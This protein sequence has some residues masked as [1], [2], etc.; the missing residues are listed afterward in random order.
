MNKPLSSAVTAIVFGLTW[1]CM[2]S[3]AA[4]GQVNRTSGAAGNPFIKE[5]VDA[6]SRDSL[7]SC[8][9]A[10]QAFGTRYEYTPQRDSAGA[11]LLRKFEERG[12]AAQS[13]W[14]GFGTTILMD[15]EIV[16]HDSIWV[17]GLNGTLVSSTDAGS[18][19]GAPSI[20]VRPAFYG[21]DF[22]GRFDGWVVGSAGTI[23]RTT[24]G[25]VNWT[26][27]TS[28]VTSVL[29]DVGF[30]DNH[31]GIA[32][33]AGGTIIRSSDGGV[34]WAKVISGTGAPLRSVAVIDSAHAWAVGDSGRIC[35]SNDGGKSWLLQV[36]GTTS[37]LNNLDFASAATGWAVGA[38]PTLLKTTNGGVSWVSISTPL[39]S[40][41]TLRSIS[42]RDS[43]IGWVA[44][45]AGDILSTADGGQTWSPRYNHLNLGWGPAIYAVQADPSGDVFCCGSQ[46]TLT[47]SQNGGG[48]WTNLTGNLPAEYLRTSRNIVATILGTKCPERECIIV[49][50]YDSFSDNPTVSAPGANDNAT[51]TSAVMEAARAC[52]L[53]A[54]ES[55]V[56]FLLVSAEEFGMYGSG[57]YARRARDGGREIAGVVNGDMIGYPTTGDTAR[58]VIGSFITR[59]R[60]IDSA[61]TYNSRY[62]IGLRLVP[63]IDQ[64]GASDY[65][66]FAKAGYDALEVAE[67]TANEIWGG[68]DPYY[69]KTSD[70]FDKLNLGMIR[71]AA[72]L[73]LATVAELAV[74]TG[75]VTS[76]P[77]AVTR[78]ELHVL[79]QNY[80]NPFNPS[81]T[82]RYGLPSRSQ[83]IVTVFNT[84]GQSVSI[85]MDGE[86]EAGYHEVR[87]DGSNLPSGVYF[88]RMQ[89]GSHTETKKLLLVR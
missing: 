78:P 53:Y 47:R 44:S 16:S 1:L 3:P 46:G 31:L 12:L 63:V 26:L 42:F 61:L 66:P 18:T 86:Q 21:M 35:F 28:P 73:M 49:A 45:L 39:Q 62:G 75:R 65:G 51:G 88:Y 15:L 82:I 41:S 9:R 2:S 64:T 24:D 83:V 87:F 69:H 17:I 48:L 58:I 33:G 50:H 29:Y 40:G 77:P 74:P 6:V 36:S 57:N 14:Y 71:R 37:Q 81:T 55:T 32:V 7:A 25:G 85:L 22:S 43:L 20:P 54:F 79:C 52:R 60:H 68:A 80:P 13:D 19:W 59:N 76:V 4:L 10:L 11:Y 84:L 34:T 38:G 8:I 27:Q 23:L 89:A 56:T 5:M 67:G 70:T 30:A 72:Q